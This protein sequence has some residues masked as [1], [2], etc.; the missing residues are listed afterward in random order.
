MLSMQEIILWQLFSKK[1]CAF[2][3][4]Q[5]GFGDRE[6]IK[7]LTISQNQ[8]VKIKDITRAVKINPFLKVYSCIPFI[9]LLSFRCQLSYNFLRHV[10]KFFD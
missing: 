7:H 5:T 10:R 8:E 4:G 6:I 1:L 2:E 9:T 3:A